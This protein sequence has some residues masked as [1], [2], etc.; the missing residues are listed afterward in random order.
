MTIVEVVAEETQ[1]FRTGQTTQS[2]FVERVTA[3]DQYR[4]DQLAALGGEGVFSVVRHVMSPERL[5]QFQ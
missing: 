1:K 4:Q 2:E 5:A 3:A